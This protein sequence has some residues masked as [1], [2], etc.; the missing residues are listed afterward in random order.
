LAEKRDSGWIYARFFAIQLNL[1]KA[2]ALCATA[3]P[4]R[5]SRVLR[6][7]PADVLFGCPALAA[8]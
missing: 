5:S 8:Y 6:A 4:V 1:N 7:H 3:E 2:M